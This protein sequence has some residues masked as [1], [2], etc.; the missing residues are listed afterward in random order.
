MSS[1]NFRPILDAALDSY[2]KQTGIDLTKHPSASNLQNCRSPDDVLQ[3]LSERESA[4]KDYR[5]QHRNLIDR[6]RPV[7]Q[8]VHA[9]SAVLGEITDFVC[10]DVAFIS[11]SHIFT[12]PRQVPF[13]PTKAI[14]VGV[15]VLLSVRIRVFFARSIYDTAL[16]QAAIGVS[17]SYDALADLFECVSNFTRRFQIYTEKISS[18]PAMSDIVVKIM[19]EILSVLALATKQINQGRFSKWYW[20]TVIKFSPFER[21]TE[22]FA[23]KLLGESE[24]EAV[25]QRL[26]RLTQEEARVA[27]AHTLEVV[28]GLF[29]NL[30]VVMDGVSILLWYRS[31]D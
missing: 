1:P 20:H 19:V 4:F 17:A 27:L 28:H 30:R 5:D 7:V 24:V 10:S 26:D 22:K 11:S 29:D 2:A 18:S 14:F 13:H 15:D 23:K 16:R 31:G 25:L 12:P 21:A 9:L 3:I 6:V 8:A